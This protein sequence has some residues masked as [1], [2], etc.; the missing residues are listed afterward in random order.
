MIASRCFFHRIAPLDRFYM[1]QVCDNLSIPFLL[2]I[3][4]DLA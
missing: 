1:W 2:A 3:G 4:G